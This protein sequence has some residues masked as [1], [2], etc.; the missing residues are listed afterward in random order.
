MKLRRNIILPQSADTI[1]ITWNV[2]SLQEFRTF[3]WWLENSLWQ[4]SILY[5]NISETRWKA[6]SFSFHT[7][8]NRIFLHAFWLF[9]GVYTQNE[10]Y[11]CFF[12][13]N[14][15]TQQNLQPC[16][17]KKNFYSPFMWVHFVDYWGAVLLH[18]FRKYHL[19]GVIGD[20]ARALISQQHVI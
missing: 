14:T 3:S 10:D 19:S 6:R 15:K 16:F 9:K 13:L 1:E 17:F 5:C 20:S 12:F 18:L 2:V 11:Y 8:K 4:G 7:C